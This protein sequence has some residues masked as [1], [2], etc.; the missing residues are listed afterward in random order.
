M[1]LNK[2]KI[3]KILEL[4]REYLESN[5]ERFNNIEKQMFLRDLAT[6]LTSD[7]PSISDEVYDFL[8]YFRLIKGVSRQKTFA[9]YLDRLYS[10]ITHPK[11]LD[12]GAGRMCHLSSIL[13]KKGFK[14]YAMD[15]NIRLLPNESNTLKFHV[16]KEIFLCDEFAKDGQG[17]Q[18]KNF[19]LLVGLEPCLATEHIARQGLK[20]EKAFEILLCY[21]AHNALDSTTFRCPEE[22]FEYLFNLSDELEIKKYDGNYILSHSDFQPRNIKEEKALSLDNEP[23][24]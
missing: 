4:S 8:V 10:P 14:T 11:V 15:P 2:A 3:M 24:L 12:V 9:N 5:P 21:E 16:S 13:S 18:I 19:D 1:E 20:Y 23:G 17:T 22:W 7:E 6:T